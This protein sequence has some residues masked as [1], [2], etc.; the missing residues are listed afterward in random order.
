MISAY[1]DYPFEVLGDTPGQKAP[2]RKILV[3]DYDLDKYCRIIVLDEDDEPIYENSIKAGYIYAQYGTYDECYN[4]KIKPFHPEFA[5][6]QHYRIGDIVFQNPHYNK[7]HWH[8]GHI[9]GISSVKRES[10]DVGVHPIS[11]FVLIIMS[12][13]GQK[14]SVPLDGVASK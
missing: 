8:V 1:T 6:L 9:I 7:Y 12:H 14:I 13:D 4:G 10:V 5:R 3:K 2:V 11:Q